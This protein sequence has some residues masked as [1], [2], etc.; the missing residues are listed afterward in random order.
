MSWTGIILG[1][2][3]L[4]GVS[5]T[6]LGGSGLARMVSASVVQVSALRSPAVSGLL[7]HLVK[8]EVAGTL[9]LSEGLTH[10][11]GCGSAIAAR[12]HRCLLC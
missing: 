8:R 2:R 6:D 12:L 5:V 10:T 9:G 7:T 11:F 3:D 1:V 4:R